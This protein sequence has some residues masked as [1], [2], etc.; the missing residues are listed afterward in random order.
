MGAGVAQELG[1]AE[2][3]PRERSR[4]RGDPPP[5]PPLFG[6][7]GDVGAERRGDRRVGRDDPEGGAAGPESDTGAEREDDH[8]VVAAGDP[9]PVLAPRVLDLEGAVEIAIDPHVDR[10]DPGIVEQYIA[11]IA[12]AD[13]GG[14]RVDALAGAD[15]TPPI[16]HLDPG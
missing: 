9:E 5:F 16:E 3:A 13:E 1:Q 8:P 14:H 2:A 10:R 11:P 12:A 4:G 6:G 15:M 7:R